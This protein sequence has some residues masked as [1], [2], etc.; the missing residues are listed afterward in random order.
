VLPL[1]DREPPGVPGPG[2]GGCGIVLAV[3]DLNV[4]VRSFDELDGRTSYLLWQLREA[5]FVVE[6]AC[7]Y[8]ELD[9]RDL[10]ESTRH[11]W[12][13]EQGR[14]VAYLRILSDGASARIGRV[15]VAQGHRGRGL[16]RVLMERALREIGS[17]PSV[18]DAQVHLA[19]WYE[20][21]GYRPNGPEF[22]D[23]G[24]PHLP[25]RRA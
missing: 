20:G 19:R 25:M 23:D 1:N 2:V 14:P 6:Q 5:V 13:E 15:L 3:N 9:G 24:I 22:L 18:L 4:H 7:P 11:V 12:V 21:F 8:Q 17:Q 10:E 16:A